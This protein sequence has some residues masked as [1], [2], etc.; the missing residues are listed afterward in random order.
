M[1]KAV[2]F[3]VLALLVGVGVGVLVATVLL[4]TSR[5]AERRVL[6]YRNPM[7]P[8][9]TSDRP[10]KDP[11][12][13][14]YV[15]VY[16]DEA[17][18]GGEGRILFYRDPDRPWIT[19]D[20]PGLTAAGVERVPVR[21]GDPDATGIAI[22]PTMVQNTGVRVEEVATRTLHKVIRSGGSVAYDERN[23]YDINV[24]FTGWVERLF[25]DFTGQA[26]R[27]G[28]PLMEVYSPE[29]VSAQ[30]EYLAAL[31]L[32][33][34]GGGALRSQT[35]S[36]LE[37]AHRR[38]RLLDVPEREIAALARRKTPR[39]VL[40]VS[41]PA[42]GVVVEKPVLQGAQV[43]PGMMLLKVADLSDV[44]VYAEV[45]PQDAAWLRLGQPAQV[46][47]PFLPGR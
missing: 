44:W 34:A 8:S 13:M 43:Q 1:K 27:R 28:D 10:M 5:P 30:Q 41:S 22:N 18:D 24:K 23:V 37:S 33:E 35:S 4:P 11:M 21:E 29:L 6:Y 46:T 15:P 16:S 39:R 32:R 31:R 2:S 20:D 9:V 17:G 3:A 12:G 45:F 40:T 42:D 47:L 25:V 38:L 7:D 19:F 14:D 26:V 36:L